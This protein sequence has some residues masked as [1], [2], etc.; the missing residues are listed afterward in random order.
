MKS[1]PKIQ[2]RPFEM[3]SDAMPAVIRTVIADDES[4][5][6][7]KLRILLDSETGIQIVAECRNG[8]E[9]IAAVRN[10]RPDLLFLDVQMPDADGFEVLSTISAEEMPVTVFTT[11]YD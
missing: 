11:A 7:N 10:H 4:L 5:A 3:R 9:A 2:N 1:F 8:A 6:R